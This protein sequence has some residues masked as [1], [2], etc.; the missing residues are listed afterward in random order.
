M[1]EHIERRIYPYLPEDAVY[2]RTEVFIKE[3]GFQN[4]FDAF[5]EQTDTALHLVLYDSEKPAAT[6]RIVPMEDGGYRI[7]RIAVLRPYRGLGLGRI[8]IEEAEK[9]ISLR[10]AKKI[11]ISAQV[12][13]KGFY[14][15]MGYHC[16]GQE[17]PDEGRPHILMI[18]KD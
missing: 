12:R 17:Y 14:E 16:V 9:C 1:T 2:I 4:E 18:K 13:V 10:G 3:Q 6:C 8:L 5:D 15:K 11:S 7:G